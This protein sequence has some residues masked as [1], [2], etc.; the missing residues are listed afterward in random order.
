MSLSSFVDFLSN[1]VAAVAVQRGAEA[2][3]HIVSKLDPKK[4]GS[5]VELP[6][7]SVDDES[8]PIKISAR[9]TQ[10]SK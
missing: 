1:I 3:T 2:E 6:G 10:T 9:L 5:W 7:Y 4:G 8:K